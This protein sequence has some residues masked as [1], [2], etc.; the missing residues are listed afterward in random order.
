MNKNTTRN[1]GL[2]KAFEKLVQ[3]IKLEFTTKDGRKNFFGILFLSIF[4]WIILDENKVSYFM[5]IAQGICGEGFDFCKHSVN[6]VPKVGLWIFIT[7][8]LA[9]LIFCMGY[10]YRLHGKKDTDN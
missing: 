10:I 7:L 6:D 5:K 2:N 8:I 9:C 1:N 4:V 3:M